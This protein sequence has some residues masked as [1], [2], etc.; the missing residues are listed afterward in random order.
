[1]RMLQAFP[2]VVRPHI[3]V[4]MLLIVT[5]SS[6][7]AAQ[8][9]VDGPLALPD[10]LRAELGDAPLPALPQT[11]ARD[12]NGTMT[13][14]AVRLD[15]PLNLDGE[16]TEALYETVEPISDF[17]QNL[18]VNDTPASERTDVW[19]SFDDDNVYVSVRAWESQPER[20]I[21]NE[22][23][24]DSFRLLQNENFA[25]LFDTFFDKRSSVV[26][27]FN[28]LGGRWDGQAASEGSLNADWNPLWQ[29]AVGRFENGWTAEAAVPF[30]SL[31]YGAGREQLWGFNARRINR[32]K[33]ETSY[34]TRLPTGSGIAG[35]SYAS[36]AAP[37][38][39]I[40]APPSSRTLDIKPYAITDISTDVPSGVSNDAGG[41]VGLDVRYA[42]TQNLS[43]DFT[44]N[45]DFAQVEADEQQVNLTRFSLFFPEKREFFLENSGLFSFG[46][47]N[48]G[49]FGGGN[50]APILFYSR[51]IG[52]EGGQE[53][54]LLGGA[55]LT[56][57]AGAY[58][59]G[60]INIQANEDSERGV[61]STN[62]TVARVRRDIL[63]R[64]ALGAIFTR[65]SDTNG[66]LGPAETYGVDADFAFFENLEF[67][68]SLAQTK[69]PGGEGNDTSYRARMQYDGDLYGLTIDQIGIGENFNPGVGFVRRDDMQRTF[70]QARYSPRPTSID[71]IRQFQFQVQ[72]QYIENNAGLVETR[73]FEGQGQIQFESSDQLQ[74][75][76]TDA[77]E[78]V[79]IPFRVTGVT[80]PVGGYEGDTIR[81]QFNFGQQRP[82]SA[83][84]S[85][86]RSEFYGGHRWSYAIG[87]GR[88]NFHPQLS[89]E[90]G[91]SFNDV[92]TPFGDF[93]TQLYSSRITYT[94]TPLMFV[95]GLLQYNSAAN[96]L[97]TNIRLR[98]EYLP[99]SELFVVYNEGRDTLGSGV[100]DLQNRALVV[101]VNRLFRF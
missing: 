43:A 14:R 46:G 24:R 55:R 17:I 98:W 11:V 78:F 12:G 20:M 49:G 50:S 101:K 65:R 66:G 89:I 58:S 62:F 84:L 88:M 67:Q 40:E 15:A 4:A 7:V 13:T 83:N 5:V 29:V 47:A 28:P 44:V 91:F 64:S 61:P 90:P 19:I 57:R 30:K 39:G 77:Y 53:V 23:R 59:V 68:A 3:A 34:L 9:A 31:S 41:D 16:L 6:P 93:T 79:P 56:G 21:A 85:V 70:A 94:V 82:V 33:N 45:T 71:W 74:V 92:E 96:S 10:A 99:G 38:V 2:V 1:M 51:R 72:T 26:F 42:L 22:M 27:Q 69:N 60:V 87:N 100:P 32:W 18:P 86:E 36:F 97:S 8:N 76:Y 63:R 35:I 25:F 48:G 95:S 81:A 52:L 75:Q 73:E 37:L 54:P 80:I